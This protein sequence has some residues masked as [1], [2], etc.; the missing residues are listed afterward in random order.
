MSIKGSSTL[1]AS[2]V[3]AAS[4]IYEVRPAAAQM[5]CIPDFPVDRQSAGA[6]RNACRSIEQI[7]A[8][9][10]QRGI[11]IEDIDDLDRS[12]QG[13]ARRASVQRDERAFAH[14]KSYV[15]FLKARAAIAATGGVIARI[16]SLP[17]GLASIDTA[18]R[19]WSEA[20]PSVR[21]YLSAEVMS[22]RKAEVQKR[23][24]GLASDQL[25]QYRT[26]L[27]ALPKTPN[28]AKQADAAQRDIDAKLSGVSPAVR[29][30]FASATAAAKR[31]VEQAIAKAAAEA[32]ARERAAKAEVARKASED[33]KRAEEARQARVAELQALPDESISCWKF[34]AASI[35]DVPVE[36]RP[37]LIERLGKI[38]GEQTRNA[39][40]AKPGTA[41]GWKTTLTTLLDCGIRVAQKLTSSGMEDASKQLRAR[42]ETS[43]VQAGLVGRF[44]TWA[45]SLPDNYASLNRLSSLSNSAFDVTPSE[46]R[47]PSLTALEG[48]R[49]EI[50]EAR[51]LRLTS[52]YVTALA[53]KP[54][55]WQGLAA[56]REERAKELAALREADSSDHR[57][58]EAAVQAATKRRFEDIATA[59]KPALE[60]AVAA[61]KSDAAGEAG[62]DQMAKMALSYSAET[63]LFESYASIFAE[64]RQVI[65]MDT[66]KH[67]SSPWL[68]VT[69]VNP[70]EDNTKHSL[71]LRTRQRLG[72]D[73][74]VETRVECTMPNLE[75]AVVIHHTLH[76]PNDRAFD[77]GRSG[78][79]TL[80]VRYN[81][82]PMETISPKMAFHNVLSYVV[83]D[84]PR[85]AR[86]LNDASRNMFKDA[87]KSAQTGGPIG[88]LMGLVNMATAAGMGMGLTQF[89]VASAPDI[90]RFRGAARVI[91]GMTSNG[92]PAYVEIAPTSRELSGFIA[93]CLKT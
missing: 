88:A 44:E 59:F 38:A 43:I 39:A 93:M 10:E 5:N 78:Q 85:L 20:E 30:Q 13:S 89:L 84:K 87:E 4:F 29:G 83:F 15:E 73:D 80:Q 72:G 56:V 50:I 49:R 70:M 46:A 81:Q 27:A 14:V 90:N 79:A 71:I 61:L 31:D 41:E 26:T 92:V 91:F 86:S 40:E 2:L 58:L 52:R 24:D 19:I 62:L 7:W 9:K 74:V 12:F 21:P 60:Q 77:G 18:R 33:A 34:Y 64:K 3:L 47:P 16:N 65:L 68:Y 1:A 53:A 28:G 75:G 36:A 63:P 17:P 37:R 35:D 48:K 22:A 42:N 54:A 55:N 76:S 45:N 69:R 82:E 57:A 32:A 11:K 67:P 23:I 25:R 6:I 8:R 66:L 51:R